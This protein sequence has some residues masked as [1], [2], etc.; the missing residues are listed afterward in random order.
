MQLK[1]A[2]MKY[3]QLINLYILLILIVFYI[4]INYYAIKSIINHNL[5]LF[6]IF[7]YLK[8]TNFY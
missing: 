8:K 4:Y 3:R 2:I 1:F 7:L 6:Y 5:A